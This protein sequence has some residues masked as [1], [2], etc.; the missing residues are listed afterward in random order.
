MKD[1]HITDTSNQHQ[2]CSS[3]FCQNLIK[4]TGGMILH[5][6]QFPNASLFIMFFFFF[7]IPLDKVTAKHS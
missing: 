4:L 1:P 2:G 7:L 6:V 3:E 5:F